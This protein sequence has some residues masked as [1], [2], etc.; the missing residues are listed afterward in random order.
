[1]NK[2]C[3]WQKQIIEAAKN[4]TH[5][6]VGKIRSNFK[7]KHFYEMRCLNLQNC[8][9]LYQLPHIKVGLIKIRPS[10]CEETPPKWVEM[11][12][13]FPENWSFA[14]KSMH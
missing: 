6:T 7:I 4:R 13:L 14:F 8:L 3:W 2:K 10:K 9:G 1:M 12:A 5:M 11:A